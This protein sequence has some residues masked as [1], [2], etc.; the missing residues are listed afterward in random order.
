MK[1]ISISFL[2]V[3]FVA[4]CQATPSSSSVNSIE[5]SSLTT[6]TSVIASSVSSS[7]QR[8][9]SNDSVIYGPNERNVLE[10]ARLNDQVMRPMVLLIH[11][12]SWVFGDKSDMR[13]FRDPLVEAGYVYVSI[14]YR[15]MLSGATFTSMLN[16]IQL[17]INFLRLNAS[18]L[19]LDTTQMAV[20]GVSAGAHLGLLYAYSRSSS[21]PIDLAI[22]LVPP[23]DF[24]DPNFIAMGDPLLQLQQMNALTGTSIVSQEE[25][26]INGYP[27]AWKDFS[28]V[29][30]AETSVPT[31]VA[32]AGQDELIPTTNTPRLIDALTLNQQYIESVFF[33]NSGHSL[34]G[35]PEQFAVLNALIFTNLQSFLA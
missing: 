8:I 22:A 30:H 31:I 29:Y 5:T 9:V 19:K 14:N 17:A 35:D 3:L 18:F 23:V 6:S 25:L 4:S 11:G 21:I 13:S 27:Q 16:D 15:L 26:T 24:T 10:Y 33:P 12:G 34:Q 7:E 20:M 32:Y 28:P 2:L 1:K